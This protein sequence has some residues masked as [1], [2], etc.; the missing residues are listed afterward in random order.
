MLGIFIPITLYVKWHSND[1][2]LS[3]K[4]VDDH[5]GKEKLLMNSI[6]SFSLKK[7]LLA[8]SAKYKVVGQRFNLD[9]QN[10]KDGYCQSYLNKVI[11]LM[12]QGSSWPENT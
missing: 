3:L 7:R 4:R 9:I 6:F 12:V 2:I 11:G 1:G 10:E 5:V 8:G